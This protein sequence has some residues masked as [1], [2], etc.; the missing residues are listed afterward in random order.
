MSQ[1]NYLAQ[2]TIPPFRLVKFGSADNTVVASAAATDL[3][4]GVSG[5][6]KDNVVSGERLDIIRD[7]RAEVEYGGTVTRGQALTSDANGKAIAAA[8][9][10]SRVIGYADVSA[11]AGDIGWAF[12]EIGTFAASA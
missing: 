1:K 12:I 2:G 7:G 9:T 6:Y 4:I 5:R 8:V 3:S 11:V 10:G